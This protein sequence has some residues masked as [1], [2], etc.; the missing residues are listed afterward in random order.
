VKKFSALKGNSMRWIVYHVLL[1]LTLAP[2]SAQSLSLWT[3]TRECA[4]PSVPRPEGWRFPGVITSLVLD[5]GIRGF[6]A[7]TFRTYY[8]AF[9][10]SNFVEGAALSPDGTWLAVPYGYIQTAAA[11][12]VRYIVN[13]LRLI[14]TGLNPQIQR[15]LSWQA[16][17][18]YPDIAPIEWLDN[19]TLLFPQGSFLQGQTLQTV[20]PLT[21]EAAPLDVG[22]LNGKPLTALSPDLTYAFSPNLDTWALF[23]LN[24][25]ERQEQFPAPALDWS[26]DGRYFAGVVDGRS[27]HL[28]DRD[29]TAIAHVAD[30]GVDRRVWN[31]SFAPDGSRFIYT[32]YDPYQN[33]N[34]LYIGDMDGETIIDTCILLMN[35]H[36][37]ERESGV[38]WSPDSTQLVLLTSDRLDDPNALQIY[39]LEENVRYSVGVYI[40]G[41]IG[42]GE[43]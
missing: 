40:G 18:Q 42:W 19:E 10:G 26:P 21:N 16:S 25:G 29:G 30:V 13:E 7:D 38:L 11:F 12:D 2:P 31:F 5:D 9:A 24:S 39:D 35:R 32:A 14:S 4:P 28:Y 8:L 3:T 41:L 6:R 22:G 20:N 1:L 37:G 33:E 23:D 15:Q 27:L 36:D 43:N 34:T 17:F